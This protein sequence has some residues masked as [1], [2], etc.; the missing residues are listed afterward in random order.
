MSRFPQSIALVITGDL[1]EVKRRTRRASQRIAISAIHSAR[2][3]VAILLIYC[4]LPFSVQGLYA[5]QVSTQ[6]PQYRQLSYA[7]L[8]QLVAPIALYPDALVA[9]I[10]A[11]ATYSSQ[12]VEADRFVQRNRGLAPEQLARM[13]D[14]QP[15]DPRACY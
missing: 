10:L 12:V 11:A 4:I 1:R 9:Q 14:M 7:D 3:N 5:Q 13:V 15:W 8:D 2:V 6:R